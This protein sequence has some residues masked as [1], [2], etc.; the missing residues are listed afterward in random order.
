MND[1]ERRLLHNVLSSQLGNHLMQ[2]C[3]FLLTTNKLM[4]PTQDIQHT[5]G[6]LK[7]S[8]FVQYPINL[9][10]G[11]LWNVNCVK[12]GNFILTWLFCLSTDFLSYILQEIIALH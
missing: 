10:Q 12:N 4:G 9:I 2:N 5:F 1:I 3:P 11:V 7:I 8:G 6:K